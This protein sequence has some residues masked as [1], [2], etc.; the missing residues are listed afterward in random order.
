[1]K[2]L[3]VKPPS[4]SDHIQPPIGL[5]Y[6]A[7]AIQH[8]HSTAI[9]DMLK[10]RMTD[11]E[12]CGYVMA[13]QFDVVGFQC[14]TQELQSVARLAALVKSVSTNIVTIAGGP[15]PTLLPRETME[16]LS[17]TLDFLLRGEGDSTFPQFLTCLQNQLKDLDKVPGLVWKQ[18][19]KVV[20]NAPHEFV[21]DLNA[22]PLPAWE[23]IQPQTYP[24]AQHGA[25]FKKFP[26]APIVTTRGCPYACRFCS[27]PILSGRHVRF[28]DPEK[29]INEIR[30]LHSQYG[31]REIHIIDDNFTINRAH[32]DAVLTKIIEAKLGVS[33]AFPN[34]IRVETVDKELLD[35]MKRAGAYLISLGIESGSD[36]VLQLM[37][38]KLKVAATEE[39]VTLIHKA[40]LDIAGFFVIGFPGETKE[41]IE[42]TIKFS[43][44]LPLIRANYFDFLP[45]PGTPIYY[46][47]LEKGE[48][49]KTDWKHF[50][51]MTAPYA[52][53]GMTREELRGYQRKAFLRF[54]LRPRIFVRNILQIKSFLHFK[55]LIRRFYH[56][57]LM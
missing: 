53:A 40:K 6:L 35:L 16:Y 19:D 10:T 11:G 46:E 1:V 21:K 5:A 55:Y 14:Y 56:W 47:L 23:L 22:L 52:P 8:E 27:A 39:K 32:A 30:L 33:I 48:L 44:K 43:L 26:I 9:L 37:N 34:G 17:A 41:D 54:Y 13:G 57:L 20:E 24:P 2:V 25:F 29:I 36:R 18:A 51:F 3:L 7:G 31:I 12:F 4:M 15:H 42:K 38:K 49:A 28:H 50:H 45:L